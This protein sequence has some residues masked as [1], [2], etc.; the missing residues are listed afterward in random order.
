M[1]QRHHTRGVSSASSRRGKTP[2]A[3]VV[4]E[5]PSDW[6]SWGTLDSHGIRSGTSR[7]LR[8]RDGPDTQT[9]MSLPVSQEYARE[10]E[11]PD[12]GH[13]D[14]EYFHQSEQC[15]FRGVW[16]H[17]GWFGSGPGRH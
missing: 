17:L 6:L 13:T 3:T 8:G 7:W 9:K 15:W 16:Q 10:S 4:S 2:S 11:R 14:R 1:R 5:S 12:R